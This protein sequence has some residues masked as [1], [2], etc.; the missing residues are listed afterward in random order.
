[1][2]KLLLL[3]LAQIIMDPDLR[4]QAAQR[5]AEFLTNALPDVTQDDLNAFLSA[6]SEK[7]SVF[8]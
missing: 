6:V 4:D 3:V 7:L 1:L 5:V 2:D 8:D